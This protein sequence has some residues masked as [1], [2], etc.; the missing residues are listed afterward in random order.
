MAGTEKY[1]KSVDIEIAPLGRRC[2]IAV[3]GQ[4][5]SNVV[6]KAEIIMEATEITRVILH[7]YKTNGEN[8]HIKG[9]LMPERDQA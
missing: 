1:G 9:L 8:F 4:D 2:K 6:Y 5:I 7:C 3:D